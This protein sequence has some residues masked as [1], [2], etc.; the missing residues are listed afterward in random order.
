MNHA[1]Y[2]KTIEKSPVGYAYH[3][4]IC[5]ENENPCDYEFLEINPA[6]EKHTGLKGAD[7][8]GK[9]ISEIMPEIY[10]TKFDWIKFYGNIAINGGEE[11]LQQYSEILDKWY[12][13]SVY[14]PEKYYFI[15]I[16]TDITKELSDLVETKILFSALNDAVF[17]LD[18]DFVFKNVITPDDSILFMPREQIIGKNIKELFPESMSRLFIKTFKKVLACKKAEYIVYESPIP[19]D[20]RWFGANIKYMEGVGN[21]KF[22]VL[23]SDITAQKK[24]EDKALVYK[25]E[26]EQQSHLQELLFE[27]SSNFVDVKIENI[28]ASIQEAL[29]KLGKSVGADRTYV[30]RYNLENKTC[31][32][33][34]E[35]CSKN[36]K[37]RIDSSQEVSVELIPEWF[38]HHLKGKTFSVSD[39]SDLRHISEI[40]LLNLH[41]I[42]SLLAVPIISENHLY[43]F[44]G[45]NSVKKHHFYSKIEQHLLESFGKLLLTI[46]LR[47]ENE[48]E[49]I[50]KTEELERFFSVNLDL[51]CIADVYGRF[52]RVNKAWENILGYSKEYLQGRE[53]LE[54]VHPDDIASTL[55]IMSEL[56][57]QKQVSNFVNRYRCL[58]G[59]YRF[60]EWRSH[61][62]G[63]LVY[64]AARD[65][66]ER[67]NIEDALFIE[68]EIFQTTLLSIGDGVI[69]V[70]KDGKIVLLN[71]MAE[72]LTGW[73][74][75]ET[76]GKP[77]EDFFNIIDE[78]S[79]KKSENPISKVIQTGETVELSN[80]LS[81]I[82]KYGD[83]ISIEY[84]AS[85]IKNKTSEIQG[86]VLVLRDVTEKRK[87]LKQVE[88]LSFHDYLTGLYNRRFFE[89]ELIR[90]DT[91]RNLPISLIMLDV[92][93]LKLTNDAFGH[94]MG[95]ELL[96]KV[97]EILKK[98][99]RADDIIARLGGDEFAVILP[100]S[101]ELQADMIASRISDAAAKET[102]HSIIVSVA[103]GY[104]AKICENQ[105]INDII[106]SSEIKMY[107][108]KIKSSKMVRKKTFELIRH[109]LNQKYKNEL[110]HTKMVGQMCKQIGVAMK[111]P[112]EQIKSLEAAGS[113]H[114]IGKI[115]IPPDILNNPGPLSQEEFELVQRHCE[116]GYQ[117]LKSV[118][119]YSPLARYVL[120][121]HE[122]WDG[123]GYPRKQKGKEIPLFSRIISIADA[124]DAMTN[125]RPY[126]KTLTKEEAVLEFKKNAG[127]QF[128]PEIVEIF[129][130][131]V[132][133]FYKS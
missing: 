8:I 74:H 68:K 27:I 46:L 97:A 1:F 30:F 25:K 78:I 14:S 41:G 124:Y 102:L 36:V 22:A 72:Q 103:S 49:I 91:K 125:E 126:K 92:N 106:K 94:E 50:N 115:I 111:L 114:D 54:F 51:L 12:M 81:L 104:A 98:Q 3:R 18:E 109:N 82:N 113:F 63:D 86:A 37:P 9:K 13:I 59:T 66:T 128:D 116:S 2:K 80:N 56:K 17:Q 85:P 35:W 90:L 93:G 76:A 40:E 131:K 15:T 26:L 16:F 100:K 70:D 123:S 96:K 31:T 34:F 24:L 129:I 65:I 73:S 7:L 11:E 20:F 28:E 21:G 58:D 108:N 118:E 69:S 110:A 101:D 33:T 32:N 122:R 71:N 48:E 57:N 61:P 53:F 39:I 38:E 89:E 77:F 19:D 6:F 5:D 120:S 130:E 83:E 43:G 132:L 95:D 23:I 107:N 84:S 45:F 52:I 121:H 42:K 117:I 88:Y 133:H 10:N 67:K 79:R 60:I 87:T 44:V 75:S 29:E 47:K 105:D 112:D 64:A 119:E 62:H 127:T 4:I 55:G 99:C